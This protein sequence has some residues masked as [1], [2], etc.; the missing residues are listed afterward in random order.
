[1]RSLRPVFVSSLLHNVYV[2]ER[3][4]VKSYTRYEQCSDEDLV[5]MLERGDSHALGLLSERHARPAYSVALRILGDTAWAEK[6][7][8]DVMLRLCSSPRTYDPSRG[9]LHRWL[10]VVTHNAAVTELRGREAKSGTFEG[11]PEALSLIAQDGEDF[12]EGVRQRL[13]A[14][15]VR[16]ALAELPPPQRQAVEL[17]YY[18]GLSGTEIAALVN[19]PVGTVKA[20]I[21]LALGRLR[22]A[23]ERTS[24]PNEL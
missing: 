10:L 3:D 6:V 22:T 15:T 7:V 5:S 8:Q 24:D 17:A 2:S 20:R 14:D 1:M 23:L 21:R 16:A 13:R 11:G 18:E 12:S 4:G 19:E 9:D